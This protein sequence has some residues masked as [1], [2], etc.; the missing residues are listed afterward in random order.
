MFQ[1][2][3]GERVVYN[4]TLVLWL[5]FGK[6]FQFEAESETI[7]KEN[8]FV[9]EKVNFVAAVQSMFNIFNLNIEN[10]FISGSENLD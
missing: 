5:C 1:Q 10:I 3:I 6:V 2:S 7:A 8:W 4:S 9:I